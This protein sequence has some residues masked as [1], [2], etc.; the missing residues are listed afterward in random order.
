MRMVPQSTPKKTTTNNNKQTNKPKQNPKQT[1]K[2]K[3]QIK[4]TKNRPRHI[5]YIYI[6]IHTYIYTYIH[7]Y[8]KCNLLRNKH[9]YVVMPTKLGLLV[10]FPFTN[11]IDP[12]PYKIIT[13]LINN[14]YKCAGGSQCGQGVYE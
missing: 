11:T 9:A 10:Y 4:I 2:I 8:I 3:I 14:D 1:N 6:H 13:S 5:I 12:F 7:I